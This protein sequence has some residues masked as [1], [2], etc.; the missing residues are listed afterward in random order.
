MNSLA[1]ILARTLEILVL[2]PRSSAAPEIRRHDDP[3]SE[4]RWWAHAGYA[5]PP[6]A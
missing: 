3:P 5:R 2:R 4:A 1:E 6:Q